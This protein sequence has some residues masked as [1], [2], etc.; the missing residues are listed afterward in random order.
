ML[1]ELAADI[2]GT[3]MVPLSVLGRLRHQLI[4][5]LDASLI[6]K[7]VRSVTDP[8][9][10]A[11]LRVQDRSPSPLFQSDA[12][13]QSPQLWV[14]CRELKQIEPVLATNP[15]GIYVELHDIREYRRVAEIMRGSQIPWYLATL[16]VQLPSETGL[17]KVLARHAPSGFLIRHLAALSYYRASGLPLVADFSLN[18]ANDLTVHWLLQSGATRVTASYDLNREQLLD[19]VT[20]APGDRLEVV[21]HQHM[22]MF[23]MQHCVF[24][25]VLSPGTN[26]T[27]CGRPC[28]R[29][30]VQLV[31]RI[32]KAHELQ[33]DVGCRNTVFNGTPQSGA[34][35][36]PAL[37][38]AGVRNY[39]LELLHAQPSEIEQLV[40]LYRGL[41]AGERSPR[42]VWTALKA[43][44]RVGVTRGTLEDR[45]E[46]V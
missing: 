2:E 32:G 21:V 27:N 29:H 22:P 10:L 39:R 43:S 16:R 9:A 1:G 8:D 18:A 13:E 3:P 28:D 46:F 36:I 34:E 33:A 14:L 40:N 4:E 19:L 11:R 6:E 35:A 7:P 30:Q 45:P 42:E 23:H 41:I 24:C 5:Q 38:T 31:D 20:A 17:L 25:S 26:K 12:P 37:T 15:S 44:N